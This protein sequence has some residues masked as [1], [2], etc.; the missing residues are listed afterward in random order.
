MASRRA[1]FLVL[2][3]LKFF[4]GTV[5]SCNALL[6]RVSPNAEEN[7]ASSLNLLQIGSNLKMAR[8]NLEQQSLKLFSSHAKD[9]SS[10]IMF[11]H[12]P[13]N[14][15]T[16]IEE[17]GLAQGLVWG[18]P[19]AEKII[20][21]GQGE[22]CSKRHVPPHLH[23]A[24]FSS[25]AEAFCVI[26]EPYSRILSE[27]RYLRGQD[28]GQWFLSVKGNVQGH[29]ET[30]S[31]GLNRFAQEILR[32]YPIKRFMNDCHVI[33]QSEYI[34]GP[35][36]HQWC[37]EILRFEELSESFNSLM[38]K[39]RSPVR[40]TSH[41]NVAEECPE[42]SA[43]DFTPETLSLIQSVYKDDFAKLNYSLIPSKAPVLLEYTF[44]VA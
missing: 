44:S 19:D 32:T 41:A 5:A 25:S 12:I 30:C 13:K 21:G 39:H 11:I 36:G 9:S 26:R 18:D 23:P 43:S 38:K 37:D 40:L 3:V 6:P 29:D 27:Y 4:H 33:P 22:D 15:G 34:W 10:D 42:L 28:W 24:D 14:G 2:S 35:D 8:K 20:L 1:S 16:A 7:S 17:A 31:A